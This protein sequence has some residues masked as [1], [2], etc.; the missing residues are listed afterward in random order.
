MQ[1]I[2][3]GK[4]LS[5]LIPKQIQVKETKAKEIVSRSGEEVIQELAVEAIKPNPNQP[6]KEIDQQKLLELADSLK[7]HG[8]LQPLVVDQNNVLIAGQRRLEAAKLAGFSKVSVVVKQSDVK[9]S[10]EMS[11]VEN[12]QRENLN[13]IEQAMGYKSLIDKFGLSHVEVAERVGKKRPTVS[14]YL[15]LLK[16]PLV[17]QQ[18]LKEGKLIE[19]HAKALLEVK[20]PEKQLVLYKRIL[21]NRLTN[22]DTRRILHKF[23]KRAKNTRKQREPIL[24]EA[25]DKLESFLDTRVKVIRDGRVGK[26]QFEFYSPEE[27]EGLLE[28]ILK[29]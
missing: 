18:A 9:Q 1:N 10:L 23:R 25:Q 12:L 20:D 11:L 21:K 5:A 26:I 13:A 7:I 28:K 17:I 27:L 16:L 14:N 22:A 6:R 24:M 3:L 8:L 19:G 2:G 4:G 29:K 15:R